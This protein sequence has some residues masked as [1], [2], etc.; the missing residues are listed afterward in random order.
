MLEKA[1]IA[2]RAKFRIFSFVSLKSC[3]MESRIWNES[4]S[5]WSWELKKHFM[6]RCR[7]SSLMCQFELLLRYGRMRAMKLLSFLLPLLM[8]SLMPNRH[9]IASC[10]MMF[11][12]SASFLTISGICLPRMALLRPQLSS[13]DNSCF[14]SFSYLSLYCGIQITIFNMFRVFNTILKF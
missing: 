11:L 4:N 12:L 6:R 14:N 3:T 5:F 9:F 10:L 7:S 8:I 2:S 1:A 13:Y